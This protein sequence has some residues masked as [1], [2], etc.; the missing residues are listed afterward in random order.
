MIAGGAA[1]G[2]PVYYSNVHTI[3]TWGGRSGVS[4]LA[5]GPVRLH[6]RMRAT[7]P[8]AFQFVDQP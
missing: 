7:K 3:A 5:G 6:I 8:H 1:M 4:S 2:N